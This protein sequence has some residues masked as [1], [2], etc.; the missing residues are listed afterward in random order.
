MNP[1]DVK[2]GARVRYQPVVRPG[3]PSF[4]CV[5]ATEPWQLG[6][7]QWVVK[8]TGLGEDYQKHAQRIASHATVGLFAITPEVAGG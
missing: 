1:E 7:G 4:P 3:E 2:V 5:V 6:S 8:V